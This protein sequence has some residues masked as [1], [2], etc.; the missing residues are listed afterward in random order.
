[1]THHYY[2]C[3]WCKNCLGGC[4]CKWNVLLLMNPIS[5]KKSYF[6]WLLVCEKQTRGTS[7]KNYVDLSYFTVPYTGRSR[8]VSTIKSMCDLP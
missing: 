2:T 7:G 1:M 6:A 3:C 8:K 5:P 4:S